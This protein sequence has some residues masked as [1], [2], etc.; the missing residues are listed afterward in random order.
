MQIIR[1]QLEGILLVMVMMLALITEMVVEVERSERKV[2][3]LG[4]TQMQYFRGKSNQIW[5]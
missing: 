5:C 2:Q 4:C 3:N 1:I